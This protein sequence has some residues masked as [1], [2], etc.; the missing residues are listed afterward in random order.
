MYPKRPRI[1]EFP[2]I[3]FHR[4]S[5]TICTRDRKPFFADGELVAAV[6]LTIQRSA[7]VH[8]FALIAYCFMADHVHAVASA[9]AESAD[10]RRFV[11]KWKQESGYAHMQ[12]TGAHLWQ[13]SYYDHVLRDDEE[14]WRAARYVLE[15]PVRKGLVRDFADYPYSGSDVFTMSQLRELWENKRQG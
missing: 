14:T 6:L 5:L 2:Y 3:G 7:S 15:N 8:S 11:S 4:Y 1:K 10:L 12:T 13:P 9:T